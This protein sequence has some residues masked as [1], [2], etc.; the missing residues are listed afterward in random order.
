METTK[1][2]GASKKA[3]YHLQDD[4]SRLI[5]EK[6]C[7]FSLTGEMQYIYDILE[8]LPEKPVMD[9]LMSR[10][11]EVADKLLVWGAGDD[12]GIVKRLYPKWDFICFV[13]R[14]EAK[15]KSGFDGKEVISPET[16]FKKF[17]DHYVAI[18]S[19][20]WYDEIRQDLLAHG[21]SDDHIFN[22]GEQYYSIYHKQYFDTSII[23]FDDSE[24]FI[25]G[26]AF[27]GSTSRMYAGL[28]GGKYK[29]IIAFEPGRENI[30]LFN[31]RSAQNLPERMELIQKGL[32]SSSTILDFSG[33][34]TQ[35]A[36]INAGG[37]ESAN[38]GADDGNRIETIAIDELPDSQD[39][40]F[41]KMDVEGAELEALKG[42]RET[43]VQ[44]HPKL[45]ICLYHKPEDIF[46][47]PEYILSLSEDYKFYIRHYQ[48]SDCETLLYAI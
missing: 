4:L 45:A 28:T 38:V 6:R 20:A 27:D 40:T 18:N 17:S 41:I 31:K 11:Y 39:I 24:V 3:Y 26:G 13:D 5:Y 33:D 30:E 15:Q 22:L 29:K 1:F 19:T 7:M 25:D 8:T 10:Q 9:N 12:Y 35:G 36:R 2:L 34:G 16:F 32:W 42:A 48:L 21:V 47:I 23:S 37:G 43:I 44:N 46:E 14:D